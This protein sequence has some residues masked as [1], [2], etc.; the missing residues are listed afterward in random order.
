MS[1]Y[2]N[3]LCGAASSGS[4]KREEPPA[5]LEHPAERGDKFFEGSVRNAMERQR[6]IVLAGYKA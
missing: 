1:T 5:L 6:S 2:S 4:A 3:Q